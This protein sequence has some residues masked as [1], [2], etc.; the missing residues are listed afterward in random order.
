MGSG[1]PGPLDAFFALPCCPQGRAVTQ[2]TQR[3]PPPDW[4]A[5]LPWGFHPWWTDLRASLCRF[6]RQAPF[7]SNRHSGHQDV[8]AHFAPM[9]VSPTEISLQS[10]VERKSS[11]CSLMTFCVNLNHCVP[12][13]A[14]RGE[15]ES[16]LKVSPFYLRLPA[17]PGSCSL[18]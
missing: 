16:V 2:P 17:S 9:R 12:G 6:T 8:L 3:T 7:G 14:N 4:G 10:E 11:Q 18:S 1:P 13:L 15:F 5:A